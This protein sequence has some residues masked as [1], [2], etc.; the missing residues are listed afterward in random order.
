M[1]KEN[2]GNLFLNRTDKSVM[3]LFAAAGLTLPDA[4][5]ARMIVIYLV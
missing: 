4:I 5:K 1:S 2:L 3:N